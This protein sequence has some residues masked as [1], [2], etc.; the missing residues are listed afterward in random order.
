MAAVTRAAAETHA[1]TDAEVIRASLADPDR[2]AAI[3]DRYAAMLYRYAY[4][5]VGPEIADD[6]VAEAFLAA[7]RGRT[8]YHLDRQD[9]R[10]WL[11]GILTRQV[12]THH[13]RERARYRAMARSTH[14]AVQDG[15]ADQVAAR[16]V[17]DAARGPLAAALAD[18][19]PGDRDVLLLV[20][21]G[22]LSYDEVADALNIPQ[23]TV[24]SRL[25]RA[26]RR[27]RKAL[28]GFDPT[29]EANDD[30]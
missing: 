26:R 12:A 11:F 14:D 13:R 23:G 1:D 21:W 8:S 30:I 5:R 4:Q 29:T 10:P 20:A 17:A 27:V 3:Y 24:G 28:P 15:P 25:S 22:Q 19:T 2:F 16:V 7:F 6:L 9:A 18:L